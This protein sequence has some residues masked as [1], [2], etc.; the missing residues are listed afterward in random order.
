VKSN[1]AQHRKRGVGREFGEGTPRS[2]RG[3]R[4]TYY[5]STLMATATL[6]AGWAREGLHVSGH[7]RVE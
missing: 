2:G 6:T 7:G 1:L 4:M 3:M 5:M